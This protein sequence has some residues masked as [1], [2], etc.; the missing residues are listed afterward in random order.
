MQYVK[1]GYSIEMEDLP[2]KISSLMKDLEKPSSDSQK[3]LKKVI[4]SASNLDDIP[5]IVEQ[6]EELRTE[7]YKIDMRL[8]DCQSM[9]KGYHLALNPHLQNNT[10]DDVEEK[11]DSFVPYQHQTPEYDKGVEERVKKKAVEEA[12][13]QMKEQMDTINSNFKTA[14]NNAQYEQG[15]MFEQLPDDMKALY[16]N[17]G[18]EGPADMM[19]MMMQKMMSGQGPK[20]GE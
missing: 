2:E 14:Q 18:Q 12:M 10:T 7:L 11:E 4:Q 9:L 6:F 15:A 3:K 1:I 16:T 19:K 13:A 17:S 8:A 20:G 5:A